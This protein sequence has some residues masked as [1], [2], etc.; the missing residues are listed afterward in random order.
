MSDAVLLTGA[1]G[2]LGMELLAR[3]IER[4]DAEVICLVRAP[5]ADA[6]AESAEDHLG[7][8]L[9]SLPSNLEGDR[10]ACQDPGDQQPLAGQHRHS[11]MFPAGQRRSGAD[12]SAANAATRRA[13]V[14][15]GVMTSS[16]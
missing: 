15:P 14:S 11:G 4:D 6:A 8:G 12:S 16:T 9:L 7:S 3:L 13:R 5:S 1:T 2:F 10:A